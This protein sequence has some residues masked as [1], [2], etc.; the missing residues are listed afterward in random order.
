M[1]SPGLYRGRAAAGAALN[2]RKPLGLIWGGGD[3][4]FFPSPAFYGVSEA[5]WLPRCGEQECW[6]AQ[7]GQEC[8]QPAAPILLNPGARSG[9]AQGNKKGLLI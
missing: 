9:G 5:L 1:F 8:W 2:T 4:F 3:A 7:G 6:L